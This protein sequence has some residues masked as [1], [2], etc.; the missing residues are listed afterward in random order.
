MGVALPAEVVE[1]RV[2]TQRFLSVFEGV[3]VLFYLWGVSRRLGSPTV[4]RSARTRPPP[5]A[6]RRGPAPLG[7][8]GDLRDRST[9]SWRNSKIDH[10]KV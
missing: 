2:W 9:R 3:V 8:A 1:P 10:A 5:V 7:H 4:L 6:N